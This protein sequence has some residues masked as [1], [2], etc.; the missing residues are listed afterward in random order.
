MNFDNIQQ[1][2]NEFDAM[3][4]AIAVNFENWVTKALE[5]ILAKYQPKEIKNLGN[6]FSD[7]GGVW[8]QLRTFTIMVDENGEKTNRYTSIYQVDY[9][10]IK[11]E[12][13]KYAQAQVDSFKHK[14]QQKLADLTDISNLHISGLE[15]T[16]LAKL[17]EHQISIEQTTVMKCSKNG[18][19]FNQ[20]PCRIYVNGKMMPESKFKKL[21]EEVK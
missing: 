20:W 15:F 19:L 12:S 3:V 16:F 13:I 14:L 4:P 5:R 8:R 17:N 6:S 1:I 10:R 11:A 7:D 21:Q 2:S 18:K 9:D